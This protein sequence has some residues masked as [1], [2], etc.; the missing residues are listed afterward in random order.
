MRPVTIADGALPGRRPGR[1]ARVRRRLG[2]VPRG[3]RAMATEA[4]AVSRRGAHRKD[5]GCP[6]LALL[7]RDATPPH[8][9][10]R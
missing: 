4:P 7:W 5:G 9:N 8:K 1:G 2:R 3:S 6:F 10:V